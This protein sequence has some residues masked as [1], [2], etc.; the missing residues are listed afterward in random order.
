MT[1]GK[2]I[3]LSCEQ[4]I[5]LLLPFEDEHHPLQLALFDPKVRNQKVVM[6][7]VDALQLHPFLRIILNKLEN[8]KR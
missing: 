3:L 8:G 4:E 2:K 7:S 1:I 5:H 6:Y